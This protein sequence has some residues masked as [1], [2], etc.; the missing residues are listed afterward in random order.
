[1]RRKNLF[2]GVAVALSVGLAVP[3]V[4]APAPPAVSPSTMAP[5]LPNFDRLPAS[6]RP[7]AL[8]DAPRKLDVTYTSGGAQR[9]F[10]DYLGRTTQGL[11]AID[12]NKI[13]KEWYA[14]GYSKDSLFQSWSM[15]KSF[16]GI[17]VGIALGEGKIGSL[18]DTAGKYVPELAKTPYATVSLKNLLRMSSGIEWDEVRDVPAIHVLASLGVALPTLLQGQRKG[19]EPGSRFTYTSMNSAVLALVVAKATGVPYAQYVRDKIWT[20]MGAGA[21]WLGNDSNGNA[22]AYC[23][24]YATDRDFARFGMMIR[25]GGKANG[26]QVV[27]ASW[28]TQSTTP[29]GVSPSYGL[30]WWIDGDEGFFASGLGDQKIYISKRHPGVVIA[31]S[32]FFNTSEAETL[33]AFRALAAEIARTRTTSP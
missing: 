18:E 31:K 22:L 3:A 32:T 29:S 5:V 2:A 6:P 4:A 13:V 24:Y 20:P 17:A 14:P 30:H 1:M 12:G 26:A 7:V 27:P 33:P 15:G 10:D 8:V 28:I 16:T 11:V 25:D 23:C 19:W 9:T 21:A